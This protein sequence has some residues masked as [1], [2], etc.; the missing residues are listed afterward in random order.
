MNSNNQR[1]SSSKAGKNLT[2]LKGLRVTIC[3]EPDANLNGWILSLQRQRVEVTCIWP[4][5][6]SRLDSDMDVFVCEY[7]PKISDLVPWIPGDS[8]AALIVLLP[9]NGQYEDGVI[10]ANAPQGVLQ[11]PFTDRLLTTALQVAWSQYRYEKRLL[12]RVSKLDENVRSLRDVE[13]AKTIIMSEQ[14]IDEDAA[15]RH[16]RKTAMSNQTSVSLLANTIVQ[17][18]QESR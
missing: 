1:N 5:P 12:D 14:N 11:R 16:I 2:S 7:F 4:P 15:Y 18:S 13:R 10:L 3:C 8:T 6:A 17:T 9:Q